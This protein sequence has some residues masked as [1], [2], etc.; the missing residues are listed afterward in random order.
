MGDVITLKDRE[1]RVR[2]GHYEGST[3]RWLSVGASLETPAGGPAIVIAA[4][5]GAVAPRRVG[6]A[7]AELGAPSAHMLHGWLRS[8]SA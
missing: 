6:P 2:F 7:Q 8:L 4:T 1:L 3:V 5:S